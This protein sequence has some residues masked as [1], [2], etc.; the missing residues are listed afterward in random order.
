METLS[1]IGPWAIPLLYLLCFGGL[2]Y[3]IAQAIQTG[4]ESY[5]NVYTRETVSQ[6]EDLF[7]FIPQR[8]IL[9]VAWTAAFA[10]FVIFFLLAGDFQS[11][12][13]ALQGLFTGGIAGGIALSSPRWIASI[14]RKR[15][16]DRFNEQLVDALMTMGNA[17]K[18]GSS[19]LQA[20]EHVAKES[21]NPMAQEIG[22]FLQE[23]RVGVKFEDAL[24]NLDRRI[25]SQDLTLMIGAVETARQTGGNL[26][27]VFQKISATIR[28]RLRIQ[29]QI[30]TLTAQ[31][32]LQAIFVG[33]LPAVIALAML[34]IDPL[35]MRAFFSSKIGLMLVGAVVIMEVT[36]ALLIRKIMRIDV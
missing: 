11:V 31:N 33:A 7:L 1:V 14:A 8:R 16:L 9:E 18:S 21:R 15:R 6:F 25:G 19:I 22:L 23:T 10:G 5:S 4:A 20:F 12:G 34:V 13:G 17:L 30:R 35:M 3:A 26:T 28:E 2:T 29:E 27:E 36:G 32:R 24:A